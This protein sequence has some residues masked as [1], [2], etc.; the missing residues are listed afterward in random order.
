YVE[1]DR[2][3]S[4]R[5]FHFTTCAAVATTEPYEARKRVAATEAEL[6]EAGTMGLGGGLESATEELPFAMSLS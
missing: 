3:Y 2:S 6:N 4:A 1:Y 5:G